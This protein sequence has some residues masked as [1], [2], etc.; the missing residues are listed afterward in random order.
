MMSKSAKN[1]AILDSEIKLVNLGKEVLN[2][3]N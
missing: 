3:K 2:A 1:N